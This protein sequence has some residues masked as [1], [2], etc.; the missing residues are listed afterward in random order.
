MSELLWRLRYFGYWFK[1][2]RDMRWAKNAAM[3][4]PYVYDESPIEAAD[5]ELQECGRDQE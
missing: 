5:D 2:T 3:A 4:A 1:R